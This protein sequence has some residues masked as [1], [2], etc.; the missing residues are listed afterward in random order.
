MWA[1]WQ[2]EPKWVEEMLDLQIRWHDGNLKV[3][4]KLKERPSVYDRVS[5]VLLPSWTFRQHSDSRWLTLGSCAKSVVV[6][7]ALGLDAYVNYLLQGDAP[8]II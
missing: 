4:E 5:I 8:L 6:A 1:C 2:V 3:S 7:L